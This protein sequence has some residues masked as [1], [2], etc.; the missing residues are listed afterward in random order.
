MTVLHPSPS[1]P[2]SGPGVW[3]PSVDHSSIAGRAVADA[4]YQEV[5]VPLD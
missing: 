5:E 4:T 2:V 3:P 1:V